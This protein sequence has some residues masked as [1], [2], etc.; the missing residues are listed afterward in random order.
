MWLSVIGLVVI[1]SVVTVRLVV[2]HR[3]EKDKLRMRAHLNRVS[4]TLEPH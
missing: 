4:G 2:Q 1:L 3:R